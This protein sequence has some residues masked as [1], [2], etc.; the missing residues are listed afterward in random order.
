MFMLFATPGGFDRVEQIQQ[1]PPIIRF[2]LKKLQAKFFIF[3]P[4]DRRT[5][6]VERILISGNIDQRPDRI[7]LLD[8]KCASG[9]ASCHR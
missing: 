8:C 7:I 5:T 4:A 3:R 6:D 9:S 2:H 1:P